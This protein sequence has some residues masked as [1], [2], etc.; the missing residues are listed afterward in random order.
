VSRAGDQRAPTLHDVARLAGVSVSTTSRALSNYG[1]IAADTR[2]RVRAAA[3]QL[4]YHRN[5]LARSMITGQ[6]GTIGVICADMGSPFFAEAL[7]A[8][9]DCAKEHGFS[10]LIV[11]TDERLD[12][13]LDALALLREKQ[14][15]GVI[16]SPADVQ[17]VGHLSAFHK[18]GRP[19]VLFDRS[20]SKL[21]VDSVTVDDVAAVERCVEFF[22]SQGHRRIGIV[23]ELRDR[24]ANWERMIERP[25]RVRRGTLNP[26]SRRL[27]GYL[28]AHHAAGL[29]VHPELVARTGATTS[30]SAREATLRLLGLRRPPTALVSV[31]NATSVGAF[32][33]VHERG[34]RVPDDLSFVA[35]DNLDWTELVTPPLTV[36]EQPVSTLGTAA[37]ELLIARIENRGAKPTEHLL[38]ARFIER[39]ST[40]PVGRRVRS[41]SG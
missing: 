23:T 37:A 25:D 30:Q 31:D 20:S 18:E 34:V 41:V 38:E 5:E 2:E 10:T 19:I 26:S 3:T 12:A 9:S 39:A 1:R 27:L 24:E 36:I 33:A 4:G 8:I 21:P 14:V 17:Q 7:R 6:T 35:F 22:I 28:R 15:D 32:G 29:T 13:E 40:R 16:V 11:N